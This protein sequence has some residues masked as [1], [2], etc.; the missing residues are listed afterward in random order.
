M[1]L[2]EA[3]PGGWKEHGRFKLKPL[4]KIR[5]RQG[6]IWTHPVVSNGHLYLRDQ[7]IIY[8]YDIKG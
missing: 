1:V 5:S 7:D 4:S 8:C 2:A 6:G 3:S